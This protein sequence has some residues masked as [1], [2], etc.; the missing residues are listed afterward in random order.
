MLQNSPLLRILITGAA[1]KTGLPTN[2]RKGKDMKTMFVQFIAILMMLM[3]NSCVAYNAKTDFGANVK[4]NVSVSDFDELHISSALHVIYVAGN[5]PK[6][7]LEGPKDL[8]KE[9]KVEQKGRT[10]IL[11]RHKQTSHPRKFQKDLTDFVTITVQ[12]P[13]L[14]SLDLSGASELKAKQIRANNDFLLSIS[15]ASELELGTLRC[16]QMNVS[17]SGASEVDI[18]KTVANHIEWEV[19]GASQI[20][21]E[22]VAAHYFQATLG[23]AS[24]MDATLNGV[25]TSGIRATGASSGEIHYNRCGSAEVYAGGASSVELSG[26]LQTLSQSTSSS[27]TIDTRE[28]KTAR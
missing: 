6:V 2:K 7:T 20:D 14:R 4:Q 24:Q 17:A 26:S 25:E 28:L 9:I 5:T 11:N 23:G 21:L 1:E 8:L 16:Q 15:G 3:S 27:S 18:N 10:L 22:A 19:S 13:A 12:S